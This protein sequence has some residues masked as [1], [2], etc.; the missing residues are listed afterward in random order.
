MHPKVKR[1]QVYNDLPPMTMAP[2]EASFPD[3]AT[4]QQEQYPLGRVVYSDTPL[5]TLN[6]EVKPFIKF[7]LG[8]EGQTVMAD[9]GSL[10]KVEGT[11]HHIVA[12]SR[13]APSTWAPAPL[14]KDGRQK[15]VILRLHGSNTVG[16]E[17][18]VSLAY[19]FLLT[20]RRN[21]AAKIE[22]QT[23]ALETPQGEKALAHDVMCD[24]EGD[25]VWETIEI[26]PRD[27]AM[28]SAICMTAPAISACL[29]G[30]SPRRKTRSA[31]HL[32]Q[33]EPASGA[34]CAGLGWTG[35]HCFQH[36]SAGETHCGTVA[37]DLPWR[38]HELG[39][40][41]RRQTAIQLQARTD[42]SGT[43]KQFCDSVLLGRSVAAS[44]K[45]H[46]ENSFVTEAV[47]ADAG[48]IGFVPMSS[49]GTA[50]VLRIG[51][52]GSQSFY[53][54]TEET[55]RAGK[56][57]PALCRYVYLYVPAA[58]P[59]GFTAESRLNWPAAREF[60]EMTQGWRGQAIVANSGFV[61][62]TVTLDEGGQARRVAGESIVQF[63]QRLGE[64]EK[65]SNS[66]RRTSVP[67]SRTMR[68]A[69]GCS[70]NSTN[71]R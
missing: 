31:S 30:P 12:Q 2:D 32:R 57:A 16:A 52:E 10:I 45:R 17:C 37:A 41:R 20:K 5:V 19:N 36:Q 60:A 1:L 7:A 59:K 67:S 34:V 23:T 43:Y 24:L 11:L 42:R 50:K 35:D 55:V 40:D 6:D 9:T 46:V 39:G 13:A 47:A 63:V 62:D 66:R 29:P 21:A 26:R 61:T 71:R 28:P 25:G 70:L 4:V 51:Q 65:R 68:S 69:R 44:A 54:P 22:D 27:P 56:Y 14:P 15:K 33:S 53:K 48:A 49:V 38:D 18:A 8:E 64:L 58:P 3:A